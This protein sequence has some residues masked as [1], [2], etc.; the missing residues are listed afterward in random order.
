[1]LKG[2]N[3]TKAVKARN[4][5]LRHI[6]SQL[7]NGTAFTK[8]KGDRRREIRDKNEIREENFMLLPGSRVKIILATLRTEA[9]L[10]PPIV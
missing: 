5:E 1:M 2:G 7:G 10:M 9:E 8:Q 3:A 6:Y 4:N